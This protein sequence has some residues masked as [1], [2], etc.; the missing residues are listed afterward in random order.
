MKT[1]FLFLTVLSLIIFSCQSGESD[2][3]SNYIESDDNPINAFKGSSKQGVSLDVNFIDQVNEAIKLKGLNYQLVK[4]EFL[5]SNDG[6]QAGQTVLQRDLGN[7]QLDFDF[8]PFDPRRSWSGPVD[9]ENDNITYAIDQTADAIPPFGG[10]T[11]EQTD[12]VI[13]RSFGTWQDAT[14]S[15]LD[16]TRNNDFGLDIGVVA[17]IF[18]TG[19]STPFVFADVQNCGFTDINFG[20]GILGVAFTFGFQDENDEFTDINNDGK[21]DCAFREIYYDPSWNWADDGTTNVDLESVATHEIGH[22]LSQAHFGNITIKN[23][24]TLKASPRAVM[25]ALYS[26]PYRDLNGTDKGGHCSN[27][28]E[29]PNN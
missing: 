18:G 24:G 22:G 15:N 26:G 8:V 5:T 1:K 2:S 21:I 14:C 6:D 19:G 27:W 29:W 25:N 23:N 9:G 11:A 17:F 12:D 7:K 28:A 4:I 13:E 3:D 10:L 16:L 20:G